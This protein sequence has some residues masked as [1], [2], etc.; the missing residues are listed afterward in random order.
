MRLF[1]SA[2]LILSLMSVSF[3]FYICGP[4]FHPI[5]MFAF[6]SFMVIFA[7]TMLWSL[8]ASAFLI[9]RTS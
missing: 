4:W 9:T 5:P 3:S 2:M 8:P 1:L 6:H 7:T